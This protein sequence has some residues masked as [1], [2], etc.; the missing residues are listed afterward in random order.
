LIIR[1]HIKNGVA[2]L[3]EPVGLPEG[4]AVR[5]EVDRDFASF[6]RSKT[7]AELAEEQSVEPLKS[8]DDLAG[9]W[10]ADESI[11]DF[12]ASIRKARA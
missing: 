4:T 2:V 1:G 8:L 11:D 3:D 9:S 6:W 5:I 10:P 7:L 12:L